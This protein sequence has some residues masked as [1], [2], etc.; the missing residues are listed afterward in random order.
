M[1]T[2]ENSGVASKIDTQNSTELESAHKEV[3]E[4]C[5][6]LHKAQEEQALCEDKLV[7]MS[8]D[9]KQCCEKNIELEQQMLN[10]EAKLVCANQEQDQT[11]RWKK[12][13]RGIIA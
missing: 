8:T 3:T 11:D 9:Q 4:L 1:V 6:R 13:C 7:S 5:Q 2:Q 10:L 12:N